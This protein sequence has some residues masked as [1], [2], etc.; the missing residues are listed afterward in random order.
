MKLGI[1][2]CADYVYAEPVSLSPHLA[3][4]FPRTDL[5][6][7]VESR[8]F[9]TA[10][11]ADVQFRRDLFDNLIGYCFFPEKVTE[12]PVRLEIHLQTEERNPFHFLLDS[13]GLQI[14]CAYNEDER[15][16]L[17]AF[18]QPSGVGAWLPAPLAPAAPRPTVEALVTMNMWI[19]ENL[20]YERREEGDPFAPAETIRRRAGS[21]RDFGVLLA[22]V[23]RVNG[24]AARLASWFVWEGDREEADRRAQS[25]MHAWVEAYLPGAGWI[26]LD[27]TNGS[28]CDDHFIT[29]AVGLR[30]ADIAPVHGTY[31][32]RKQIASEL[33]TSLEIWRE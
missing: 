11:S 1:R 30:H 10:A 32:G 26:G 21:C 22:E 15:L 29:T 14:P 27:P 19:H 7:S 2:Y 28:L 8:E 33:V 24:V 23:L 6:V 16:I 31:Y 17:G 20:E 9:S 3:R 12:L 13:R 18:L 4:I 5:F 25:A